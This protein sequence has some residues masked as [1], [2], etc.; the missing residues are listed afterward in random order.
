MPDR[1]Q[2]MWAPFN[3]V[4]NGSKVLTELSQEQNKISKPTLTEDK[5]LEIEEYIISA[6]NSNTEINIKYYNN[7][8][9]KYIQGFVTKL[10]PL[11]KKITLNN[12]IPIYFNNIIDFF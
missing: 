6:F 1:N 10:D 8:Q 11:N 3:S 5:I 2:I 4:I 12:K 9:Y 7:Y